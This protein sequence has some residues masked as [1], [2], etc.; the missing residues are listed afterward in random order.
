MVFFVIDKMQ[1][2]WT[3][4]KL[5]QFLEGEE[6]RGDPGGQSAFFHCKAFAARIFT[7]LLA[8]VAITVFKQD[9]LLTVEHLK[10]VDSDWISSNDRKVA[11]PDLP[12]R[13]EVKEAYSL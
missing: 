8:G 10:H 9:F 13:H 1:H 11:L 6:F 3:V 2:F 7:K 4:I 5:S 12:S